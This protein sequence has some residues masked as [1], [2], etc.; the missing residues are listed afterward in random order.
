MICDNVHTDKVFLLYEFDCSLQDAKT[1]GIIYRTA[2]IYKIFR[3][4]LFVYDLQKHLDYQMIYR[5]LSIWM[6]F[7]CMSSYM[8]CKLCI[9]KE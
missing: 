1:E 5:N 8:Y 2:H 7:L 3:Q 9:R 4:N 6:A